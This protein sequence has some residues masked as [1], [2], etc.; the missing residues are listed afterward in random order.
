MQH[1]VVA[2][3]D[4]ST[5]WPCSLAYLRLILS[6]GGRAFLLLKITP[7]SWWVSSLTC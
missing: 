1:E 7:F 5:S 6:G 2:T 4:K 3:N